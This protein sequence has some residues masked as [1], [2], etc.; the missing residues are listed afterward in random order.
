MFFTL[1]SFLTPYS[2]SFAVTFDELLQIHKVTDT[3]MNSV[4]TPKAGSL[5][6]NTSVETLFF[7]NG[8]NW[9]RLRALGSDTIVQAGSNTTIAGNG[10]N[11]S[12]YVVGQ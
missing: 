9:K 12:P 8:A 2:L 3:E 5:I 10:I 1:L 11:T 7:Y 6:Y 4:V